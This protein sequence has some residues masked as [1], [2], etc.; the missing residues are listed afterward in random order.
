LYYTH[1]SH[2]C[3]NVHDELA[4]IAKTYGFSLTHDGFTVEI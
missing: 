3:L 1:F 2:N 4:E